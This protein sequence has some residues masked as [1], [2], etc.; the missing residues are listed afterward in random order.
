MCIYYCQIFT[1]H[2]VCIKA[3]DFVALFSAFPNICIKNVKMQLWATAYDFWKKQAF[4]HIF[5]IL[6]S[7]QIAIH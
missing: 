6:L 5:V 1:V 2:A 3:L 7:T 4:W